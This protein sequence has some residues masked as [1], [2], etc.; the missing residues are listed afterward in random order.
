M[1]SKPSLRRLRIASIVLSASGP[2]LQDHRPERVKAHHRLEQGAQAVSQG[3]EA[4]AVV[5]QG[6]L[7][8]L[9]LQER[10]AQLPEPLD[11]VSQ[12][13]FVKPVGL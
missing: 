6:E 11:D 13:L 9:A 1:R 8:P 7:P 12:G 4:A 5:E 10:N 3:Q 2:V